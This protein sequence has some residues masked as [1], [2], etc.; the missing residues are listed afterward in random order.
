MGWLLFESNE[1]LLTIVTRGIVVAGSMIVSL[2]AVPASAGPWVTWAII[3][4]AGDAGC[5]TYSQ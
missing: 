1:R 2:S 4:T 3:T 5:K